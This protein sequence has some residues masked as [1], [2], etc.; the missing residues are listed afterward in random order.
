MKA[1]DIAIAAMLVFLQVVLIALDILTF[2]VAVLT[3]LALI[4]IAPNE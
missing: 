3:M 1:V 2:E 4:W